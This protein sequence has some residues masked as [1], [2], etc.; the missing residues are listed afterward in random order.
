MEMGGSDKENEAEAP[1]VLEE[2]E[3]EAPD[4]LGEKEDED[5]IF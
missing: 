3:A 5:V 4:V 1:D 2:N